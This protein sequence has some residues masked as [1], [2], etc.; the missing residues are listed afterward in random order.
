MKI[1]KKSI[2]ASTEEAYQETAEYEWSADGLAAFEDDWVTGIAVKF[3]VPDDVAEEIYEFYNDQLLAQDSFSTVREFLNY[4]EDHI[5]QDVKHDS[6]LNGMHPA[7]DKDKWIKALK[8]GYDLFEDAVSASSAINATA[9]MGKYTKVDG[10]E[11]KVYFDFDSHDFDEAE[12][13]FLDMIPDAFTK[14]RLLGTAP[15]VSLL[16][17]DGFVPLEG[18]TKVEGAID[19]GMEYWYFTR[20]G[21]GPGMMPKGVNVVD[22]YEDF[23]KTWFKTDKLLTTE[24]L[25]YYDIKEQWPPEGVTTHRGDVI[26]ATKVWDRITSED[27]ADWLSE[28]GQA[29]NDAVEFFGTSDFSN[30][31][32]EE[33]EGWISDHDLLFEDYC[34]YF[35]LNPEDVINGCNDIKADTV[36][37]IHEDDN[38]IEYVVSSEDVDASSL[39]HYKGYRLMDDHRTLLW[40]VYGPDHKIVKSGFPNER[41]ARSFVDQEL[42]AVRSSTNVE[43]TSFEGG[44]GMRA[45]VTNPFRKRLLKDISEVDPEAASYVSGTSVIEVP[46]KTTA[47]VNENGEWNPDYFELVRY[48][49]Y[50][51]P[52]VKYVDEDRLKE[53]IVSTV[54]KVIPYEEGEYKVRADLKLAY[55]LEPAQ[56]GGFAIFVPDR[57]RISSV[58]VK[59][60]SKVTASMTEEDLDYAIL[61]NK[62]FDID[63]FRKWKMP[64]V[65]PSVLKARDIEVGDVI[66]VTED[67]SE[68]NLGTVVEIKGIFMP[69]DEYAKGWYEIGFDCIILRDDGKQQ[70]GAGDPIKLHF[71]LDDYVGPL[72]SN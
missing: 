72:A 30:V 58:S 13:Y 69:V 33:F 71:D 34:S 24:E 59:P 28:H 17:K 68:V 40:D 66:E 43:G 52:N 31:D 37:K 26:A 32:I 9:W 70:A 39:I 45:K 1:H 27:I 62:P 67:A 11:K 35:G 18:C 63:S 44:N 29:Y 16:E 6:L 51:D 7:Y 54:S 49:D 53:D 57:T 61:N 3:G 36:T 23:P 5:E 12:E 4:V 46:I 8:S 10:T 56:H 55:K 41:A 64:K 21:L 19:T 42:A 14:A 20:H 48:I 2:N 38:T 25:N 50:S 65:D 15:A 22:T 47:V 60:V